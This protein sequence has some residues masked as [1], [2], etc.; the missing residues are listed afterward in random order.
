MALSEVALAPMSP[1]I[2]AYS[3]QCICAYYFQYQVMK[4]LVIVDQFANWP[5]VD[6]AQDG[7]K[8]LIEVL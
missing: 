2:A 8:G 5:I 7:S 4:Y 1:I 6:I 3:F